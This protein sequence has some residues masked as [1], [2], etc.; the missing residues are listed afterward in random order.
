MLFHVNSQVL[1]DNEQLILLDCV[2]IKLTCYWRY[3]PLRVV[4][5]FVLSDTRVRVC[6]VGTPMHVFRVHYVA[7]LLRTCFECVIMAVCVVELVCSAMMVITLV[8]I[9]RGFKETLGV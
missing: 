9:L 4:L 5:V 6:L 8:F 3:A 1:S 7:W 2:S